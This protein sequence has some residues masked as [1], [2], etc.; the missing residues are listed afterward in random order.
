M[1]NGRIL[2]V[3]LPKAWEIE[4][5]PFSDIGMLCKKNL[6]A[7]GTDESSWETIA[8]DRNALKHTLKLQLPNWESIW[9]TKVTVKRAQRKEKANASEYSQHPSSVICN[10]CIRDFNA[11]IYLRA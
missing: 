5:A 8:S 3:S 2:K 1:D 6:K 7:H 9:E 11:R 10:N 4:V